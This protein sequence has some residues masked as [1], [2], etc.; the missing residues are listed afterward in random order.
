MQSE[1]NRLDIK[2]KFQIEVCEI[3]ELPETL[4][5]EGDILKVAF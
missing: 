4:A 2:V 1:K 5:G 3:Q